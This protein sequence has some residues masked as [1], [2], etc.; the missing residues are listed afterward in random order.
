MR[1]RDEVEEGTHNEEAVCSL[2][3]HVLPMPPSGE[4]C[5]F[6]QEKNTK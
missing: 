2:I 3:G 6:I 5:L 1:R 4:Q